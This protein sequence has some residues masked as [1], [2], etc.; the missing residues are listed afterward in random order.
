MGRP[1]PEEIRA[2][3]QWFP[4]WLARHKELNPHRGW[5]ELERTP[6]KKARFYRGW[7]RD[8]A[9]ARLTFALALSASRELQSR[10]PGWPEHHLRAVLDTANAIRTA[11]RIEEEQKERE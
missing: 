6:E 7:I 1:K 4:R 2:V 9:R 11:D 3:K 5:D 8:F 10:S